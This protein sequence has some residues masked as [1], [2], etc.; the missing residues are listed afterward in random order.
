M[1]AC[2]SAR[3]ALEVLEQW[4]PDVLVSDIGMPGEDG[5]H[6]IKNIRAALWITAE[7]FRRLHSRDSRAPR[8]RTRALA[9]GFQ[10]HLSKPVSPSA[11]VA[12]VANLG[13]RARRANLSRDS[14]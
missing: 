5:Y 13:S 9:A 11:L 1:K 12:A 7:L 8:M 14:V 2:K 3:E 6:L 4:T 10:L